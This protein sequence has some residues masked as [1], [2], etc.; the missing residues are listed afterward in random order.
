MTHIYKALLQPKHASPQD[1]GGC[2]LSIP[3]D[4]LPSR[5]RYTYSACYCL[6][7]ALFTR[8]EVLEQ[9]KGED[10]AAWFGGAKFGRVLR[11]M[12]LELQP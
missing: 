11:S 9:R 7:Q 2:W 8:E 5:F 1:A 12:K 6:L 3:A 4:S 10:V